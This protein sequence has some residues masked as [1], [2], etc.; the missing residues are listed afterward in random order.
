[1]GSPLTKGGLNPPESTTSANANQV[2]LSTPTEAGLLGKKIGFLDGG[3]S[4]RGLKKLQI[5]PEK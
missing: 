2:T 5:Q 1:V 3:I 4:P